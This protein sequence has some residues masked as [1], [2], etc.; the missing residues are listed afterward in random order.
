MVVKK[1][2]KASGF[3]QGVNIAEVSFQF[4]HVQTVQ[5]RL[6]VGL[7]EKH[8]PEQDC[9]FLHVR[10]APDFSAFF[11]LPYDFLQMIFVMRKMISPLSFAFCMT[12]SQSS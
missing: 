5:E 9:R 10:V 2:K 6:F 1:T 7:S 11:R 3:K 8:L 4:V 12:F